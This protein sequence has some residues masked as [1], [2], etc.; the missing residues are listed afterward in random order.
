M[1]WNDFRLI[2]RLEKIEPTALERIYTMIAEIDGVKN[3][4]YLT[5]RLSSKVIERLTQSVIITS[6]GASNRIE[7]NKLSD[8]EV[9]EL[10][11]NVR[12]KKL[13]TRDEQEIVGYFEVL[14]TIFMHYKEIPI[15]ESYIF[16]MHAEMLRY[17]EKDMGHK[18]RYKVGS[19]R[20]EA[21][22][23][24]G[25][26][27]GI[28]FDPTPPYLVQK[29]THE[30]V[31]SYNWAVDKRIRHPLILMANFLFEFLAIHPFQDGNGRTSRLLTNLMLL[32]QEYYFALLVSHEQVVEAH[33]AEYYIALN[34]TQK[35]WKEQDEHITPWLIFF[36]EVVSAQAKQAVKILEDESI[37]RHLS[38]KQLALWEWAQQLGSFEFGRKDA[39]QALQFP[40]R[41]VESIIKKLLLM[42][43][44]E[45]IG[46]GMATRYRVIKQ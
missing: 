16:Q 6:T 5:K 24:S 9:A 2:K 20:V 18:G 11:N 44:L 32:K 13:K 36:L 29:E 14:K 8:Q 45:R 38:P 27:V 41:T 7:G 15:S 35:T 42:K 10:Y 19:N 3:S 34:K 12:I 21:Q 31:D 43:R 22:D 23:E 30:L 4:W 33:K 37:E 46:E 28:I 40:D 1:E 39:I 17:S 26:L 25:N